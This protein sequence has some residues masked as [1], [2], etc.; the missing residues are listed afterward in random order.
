M[1]AIFNFFLNIFYL[2]AIKIVLQGKFD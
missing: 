1:F 2:V